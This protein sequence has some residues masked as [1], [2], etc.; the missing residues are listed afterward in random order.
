MLKNILPLFLMFPFIG[1][2]QVNKISFDTEKADTKVV[3][4]S[5]MNDKIGYFT[6]LGGVAILNGDVGFHLEAAGGIHPRRSNIGFG[7]YM[8]IIRIPQVN[9]TNWTIGG[10]QLRLA[11]RDDHSR[12][13]GLF[14]FGVI[15]F[16]YGDEIK[17]KVTFRNASLGLGGGYE[18]G[19]GRDVNA[20]PLD[21]RWKRFFDYVGKRKEFTIWTIST[22]IKF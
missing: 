11:S 19:V 3:G 9:F 2:A 20:V 21:F 4:L 14:D 12:P 16:Q 18:F 22:G 8:S 15:N 17:N 5:R 7:P 13:Y 1:L 10:L 6:F